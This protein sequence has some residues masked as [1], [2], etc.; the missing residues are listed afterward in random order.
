MTSVSAKSVR[1]VLALIGF[2]LLL[3]AVFFLLPAGLGMTGILADI[4]PGE[5]FEWGMASLRVSMASG[6]LSIPFFLSLNIMRRIRTR[7]PDRDGIGEAAGSPPNP[8]E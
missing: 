8:P 6:L 2:G 4:S 1:L 7:N 5:N 3:I